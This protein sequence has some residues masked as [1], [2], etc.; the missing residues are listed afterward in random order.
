MTVTATS[1]AADAGSAVCAYLA[2]QVPSL[3]AIGTPV[4][5]HANLV[6]NLFG[7]LQAHG[8]PA[9]SVALDEATTKTCPD[10]RQEILS[11]TDLESFSEL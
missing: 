7:F 6:A 2:G 8:I 4:G 1:G 9:D 5:A 3:K 11:I 10:V